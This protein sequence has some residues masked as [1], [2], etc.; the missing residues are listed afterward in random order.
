MANLITGLFDTQE[1]AENAVSQLK[2]IGYNENEIT[3]VMKDRSAA[4]EVAHE[5]GARTMADVGT[6]GIVGGI[7]GGILGLI[8]AA[9]TVAIPGVGLIAA[10]PL[11]AMWAGAGVGGLAG[12]IIGWLAS[13]GVPE[14]VAP[15]YE[16]GLA[17]G[18]IVVVVSVH[19]G[20]EQR[21]QQIL[22]NT[23]V[24][25]GGY[26]TPYYVAPTYASRYSDLTPPPARVV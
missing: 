2:Q 6:G 4:Q 23:A 8:W 26:N 1:A 7:I 14:N 25:Y 9:G 3:I 5:A 12:S 22:H 21:V 17:A 24:A 19:P 16:R 10:G 15:Y 11:A 20:D 18:G 13:L